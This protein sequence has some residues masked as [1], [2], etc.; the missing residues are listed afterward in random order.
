MAE[1]FGVAV[2]AVVLD[3]QKRILLAHR[4]DMD[5]W[6]LPGGDMEL[7]E[8]PTDAA[9]RETKEETGLDVTV[10]RLFAVGVTPEKVVG[11]CFYC[12]VVGGTIATSDESDD[13]RFFSINELPE[14]LLPR[15][16]AVIQLALKYPQEIAFVRVDIP[17]F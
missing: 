7:G 11:F 6:D 4:R 1:K 2:T 8:L 13:V 15:K 14:N 17:R 16:R 3:E 9:I 5:F 12:D 10:G